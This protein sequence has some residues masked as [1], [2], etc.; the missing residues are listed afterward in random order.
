MQLKMCWIDLLPGGPFDSTHS[1]WIG[2]EI[3]LG[4][5]SEC[6]QSSATPTPILTYGDS[7]SSTGFKLVI[8]GLCV[9]AEDDDTCILLWFWLAVIVLLLL[10]R[11]IWKFLT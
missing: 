2:D 8:T 9:E 4:L 3:C 7:A 5:V 11:V 10:L 1:S 6:D